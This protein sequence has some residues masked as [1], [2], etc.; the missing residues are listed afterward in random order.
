MGK[1]KFTDEE[2]ELLTDEEREGL[3]DTSVT[4]DPV[5][6]DDATETGDSAAAG[7]QAGG[8]KAASD[9]GEHAPGDGN[10]N[11]DDDELAA[12]AAAGDDG[13]RKPDGDVV[14]AGPEEGGGPV[15]APTAGMPQWQAP[16]NAEQRLTE[17][18]TEK[19]ELARKFDDG[20]LTGQEFRAQM[21]PLD[22]EE[23]EIE[24]ARFKASISTET[25]HHQWFNVTVPAF[26]AEHPEYSEGSPLH[27]ALDAEVRKL[28]TEASKAGR[29]QLDGT[30]L[31]Q[32]HR[33][34]QSGIRKVLGLPPL[35]EHKPAP[36]ADAGKA[37]KRELPPSLNSLP[38]D[39]VTDPDDGGKYAYLD[40]LADRDPMAFEDALAK[41]PEAER[42]AYLAAG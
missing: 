10:D 32:A 28:Q 7:V 12:A 33:N 17:I 23:R 27:G 14:A 24:Q 40:R 41:L 38:A 29:S 39:D 20:E 4:D 11:D 15:S 5:D 35:D 42:E 3:L 1:E 21:K 31:D 8:D 22:K 34:V 2:L 13:E 30:I 36:N 18:E 26:I 37:P 19:D 16:E 9:D 25:V 6:D